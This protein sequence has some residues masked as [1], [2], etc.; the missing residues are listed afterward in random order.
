MLFIYF[1]INELLTKSIVHLCVCVCMCSCAVCAQASVD[2]CTP[3][4]YR[5][6]FG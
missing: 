3:Y 5:L 1:Q 4:T 6:V 2:A